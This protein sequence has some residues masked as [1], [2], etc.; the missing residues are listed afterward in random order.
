MRLAED[1]DW[2]FRAQ[3]LR[4]GVEVIDD[5]VLIRR[6]HDANMTHDEEQAGHMLFVAFKQRMDRRRTEG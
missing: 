3:E 5:V 2:V 1:I 4:I 6:I